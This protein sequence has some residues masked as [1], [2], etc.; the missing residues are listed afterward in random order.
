MLNPTI[1]F[2]SNFEEKVYKKIR[3]SSLFFPPL[4]VPWLH[5]RHLEERAGHLK[6][7]LLI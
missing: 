1:Y 2:H 6:A 3:E 7:K 4:L 5:R